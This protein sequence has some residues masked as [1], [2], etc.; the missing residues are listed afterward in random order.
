MGLGTLTDRAA[1]MT[2]LDTF[3]NEIHAA[4]NGDFVGRNSSG[5]PA[6]GQNLGTAAIPWG[7]IRTNA[8]VIGGTAVD[9]SQITR[10]TNVVLSGKTRTTSNQP[11]FITPNGSAL[12]FQIL[13]LTTNL[14]IDISGTAVTVNSDL[15]KSSLTAAPSSQNTCLVNDT[16]AADQE[17]TRLW[18]E[19]EH[20]KVITI[21]TIGTNIT[22][23]DG[24]YAAFML[25]NGSST[26]YFIALVDTSNNRLIKCRR[27]F[28]YDSALAPKNRIFF[29]N[30]DTITLLKLGWVF[31]ENNS[32]TVDVSY[33]VPVW[34]FQS[35]LSPA[36]GD[37]WYDMSNSLWKRYD[38]ATFQIVNRT[39]I[40]QFV[41]NT[42]AC[43]GAR[44]E[45]FFAKYSRDNDLEIEK[46]TSEII[47]A[48]MPHCRVNVAGNLLAFGNSL[49][50]WNIT[51]EL[52]GSADMYN[53]SEQASTMYYLY[54]KDTGETVMSD[55]SPY[56]SKEFYAPYH[57]HN[58][59]RCVGLAYNDGTSDLTAVSAMD[60]CA[61]D[62][63]W[64]RTANGFGAVNTVIRR[65]TNADKIAASILYADSA[66]D[67]AS[68]TCY[69]P[70]K[71][72]MVYGDQ[73]SDASST[74][75]FSLNSATLTTAIESIATTEIISVVQHSTASRG[76][77]TSA[78]IDLKIGD[79]V[80]NHT[81][82]SASGINAFHEFTKIVRVKNE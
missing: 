73:S 65:W 58:P 15:T 5:V 43:V 31:M 13:G 30:N 3:F 32:T 70:G 64:L 6:S 2:I 52:A 23:L 36:T 16:D 29:S 34:D 12:S 19:P 69:V 25:D 48:A 24:K 41:N 68:F 53:S 78:T 28:F 9:A 51:T 50:S 60:S 62:Q 40:G 61:D 66:N 1:G 82:G 67:G 74:Q 55:I 79:V 47:R 35:P 7:S 33:T 71:Y 18:G 80:R 11:A 14:I 21:D 17:D 72:S 26:E 44:C 8:L 45:P 22:A 75:G 10:Q 56:Y 4:M 37:Y 38:G 46:Q 42:T 49:P 39:L 76:L 63:I 77:N 27:G 81:R 57:P 20:R 59:W 54:L